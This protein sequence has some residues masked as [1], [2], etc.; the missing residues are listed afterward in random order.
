MPVGSH[1]PIPFPPRLSGLGLTVLTVPTIQLE[2]Q[3]AFHEPFPFGGCFKRGENSGRQTQGQRSRFK[4]WRWWSRDVLGGRL[5]KH[6]RQ[7]ARTLGR[8]KKE[9]RTASSRRRSH[10]LRPSRSTA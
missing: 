7:T 1:S 8:R 2:T 4:Y 5:R 3:H 10:E 6:E 9:E